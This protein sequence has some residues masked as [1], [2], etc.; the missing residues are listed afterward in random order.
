MPGLVCGSKLS[1]SCHGWK[2]FPHYL[3]STAPSHIALQSTVFVFYFA[4][5][6]INMSIVLICWYICNK[7]LKNQS[8]QLCRLSGQEII[9][10][11][12]SQRLFSVFWMFWMFVHYM[13]SLHLHV[14]ERWKS[15]RL[16]SWVVTTHPFTLS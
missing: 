1:S 14:A 4:H 3:V 12:V 15:K 10:F 13:E 16:S 9:S 8:S 6:S 11:C 7:T 2:N 5:V